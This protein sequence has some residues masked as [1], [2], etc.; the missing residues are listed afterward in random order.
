[1]KILNIMLSREL[2]G[3]QQ[4]FLDYHEALK[5]EGFEVINVTSIFA[6]INRLLPLKH[7]LLNFGPWD[8]LSR[9]H[10]KL[11]GLLYRPNLIIAHGNRAICFTSRKKSIPVIGVAHNYK[12]KDFSKCDYII[13]LTKHMV[14]HLIEQKFRSDRIILIPNMIK[15]GLE[16]TSKDL[17]VPVK[18]GTMARFVP[19]KGIDV[20]I[21]SL[22]RLKRQRYEFQVVIGGDGPE[23]NNLVKL[24]NTQGLQAEVKFIGW[25]ENKTNFFDNIDIF[26]L[27][28][29][30]EPFGIIILEAMA[31]GVP[32]V[33]TKTEGPAEII[34]DPLDGL[35]CD[36]NSS[37]DLTKKIAYLIDNPSLAKRFTHSSYLRLSENY[38]IK[39]VS[40][41]LSSYLKLIINR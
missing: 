26:V 38:D 14:E 7:C 21:N 13:A 36:I 25:V 33:A 15:L 39:I 31:N 27:P 18:I 6:K 41:L 11:I 29:L 32:V 17:S 9:L 12:L 37:Q 35:L 28:S 19:K 34:R 5:L 30:H 8:I 2:G 4:A 1:M 3:I 23:K 20:F 22:I 24:I 10:L 16:K 40:K